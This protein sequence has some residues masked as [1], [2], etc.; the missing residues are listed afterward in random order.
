MIII[1]DYN[2]S[3]KVFGLQTFAEHY[4]VRIIA[5]SRR[6]HNRSDVTSI[7]YLKWVNSNRLFGKWSEF[8]CLRE[9]WDN[10][11]TASSGLFT[12]N[13]L[14]CSFVSFDFLNSLRKAALST[15]LN[16]PNML[17]KLPKRFAVLLGFLLLTVFTVPN[18]TNCVKQRSKISQKFIN[19]KL[20]SSH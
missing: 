6:F 11:M 17:S 19:S 3:Q 9:G 13:F 12:E 4:A 8:V 5:H 15:C 1:I 2:L 18:I 10:S 20:F 16:F 7:K 14:G